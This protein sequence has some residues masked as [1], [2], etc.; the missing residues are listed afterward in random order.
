MMTSQIDKGAFRD[1]ERAA[2]DRIAGS[3][4]EL[5]AAVTDCAIAPLL[6]AAQLVAGMRLLDVAAGPGHLTRAAADRGAC[7]TGCDLAPAM[8]ELARRFNPGIRFDEASADALPYADSSF[9]AVV[10]AFGIGHFPDPER[11][12]AEFARVAAPGGR[13]AL[14]WWEGFSRNRINGIFH[15]VTAKL[16]VSAPDVLPQGPPMDRFSDPQTFANFMRMAGFSDVRLEPVAST[17]RVAD[18]DQLWELA[19]GSFARASSLIRAQSEDMQRA[20]RAAVGEAARR[21]AQADGLHIPI[22]FLVVSGRTSAG[23]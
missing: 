3:Y 23:I 18:I 5:F 13:A 10:C 22:A 2:H 9:D 7:A 14:S 20:I 8:V 11:V 19:M 12:M 4:N 21:Y 16:G 1:F 6:D 17:Y 15:E